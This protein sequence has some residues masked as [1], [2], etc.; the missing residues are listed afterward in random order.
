MEVQR[1]KTT[2][3]GLSWLFQIVYMILGFPCALLIGG[4]SLLMVPELLQ[5]GAYNTLFFFFMV[6]LGVL[7]PVAMIAYKIRVRGELVK[8]ILTSLRNPEVFSPSELNEVMHKLDGKYFGIDVM[9]GTLLYI[10]RIRKG[11]V[12]VVGMTMGD[13]INRELEGNT[14]RLYTRYADLPCIEVKTPW[15]RRWYDTLG[16]MEY[17]RY[18]T[19]IPF[20]QYVS[21]HVAALERDNKIHIPKLA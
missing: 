2:G 1:L 19:A 13:W 6:W 16:A 20:S 7:I 5:R 18:S 17:K 15:A 12:D 11:E 8:G 10:H 3:E 21:Q 14:L 9:N 4:L